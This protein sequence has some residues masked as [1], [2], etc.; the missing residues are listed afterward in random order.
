[1]GANIKVMGESQLN[2]SS[3]SVVSPLV[4]IQIGFEA[5][6]FENF[7]LVSGRLM[8]KWKKK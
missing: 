2:D 7:W 4:Q 1:M 6:K 5:T 3:V 8:V